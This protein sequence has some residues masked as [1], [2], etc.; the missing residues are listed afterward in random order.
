MTQFETT[1]KRYQGYAEQGTEDWL[2]SRMTR[3]GSSEI[4]DFC[5]NQDT[6]VKRKVANKSFFS[7]FCAFGQIFERV[8]KAELERI[9]ETNIVEVGAIPYADAPIPLLAS[10]DGLFKG[11]DGK[12]HLIEIKCPVTRKVG[13]I[14]LRYKYQMEAQLMCVP[15]ATAVYFCD[16][17]YRIKR[18]DQIGTTDYNKLF[19]KCEGY[20]SPSTVL[21]E[22][23]IQMPTTSRPYDYGSGVY[24]TD[25]VSLRSIVPKQVTLH[26]CDVKPTGS[27][28]YWQMHRRRI[29]RYDSD[30]KIRAAILRSFDND[31]GW[32][33]TLASNNCH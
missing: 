23:L 2:I 7:N 21:Q 33:S 16:F 13:E 27:T 3:I 11:V 12:L 31:H 1:I 30:P 9:F 25:F 20:D 10:P 17:E 15:D 32:R 5:R 28:L 14:P 29:Q 8:A 26:T 22:G 24:N 6:V 4:F 18:Q 19:H